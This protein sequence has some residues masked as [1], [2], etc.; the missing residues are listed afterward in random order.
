[1]QTVQVWQMFGNYFLNLIC[2]ENYWYPSYLVSESW[3]L[4]QCPE[5][6][7]WGSSRQHTTPCP[8]I[9]P[10]NTNTVIYFHHHITT[11][12]HWREPSSKSRRMRGFLLCEILSS[13]ERDISPWLS[14]CNNIS[15]RQVYL[16]WSPPAS[17][18]SPARSFFSVQLC[19]D[20]VR[21]DRTSSTGPDFKHTN[22]DGDLQFPHRPA[23]A[24]NLKPH[25]D[26]RSLLSL[27][28]PHN[29][30]HLLRHR[31]HRRAPLLRPPEHGHHG[32]RV[33]SGPVQLSEV[34]WIISG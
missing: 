23:G 20:P 34:E 13:W 5:A 31:G 26:R 14:L 3:E 25:W 24:Q 15:S 6:M 33:R 19:E 29:T 12:L 16:I 21:R 4:V 11:A 9:N 7:M 2:S 8:A 28:H 18:P 17:Q 22:G 10:T 30:R 27:R 1:M 32:P